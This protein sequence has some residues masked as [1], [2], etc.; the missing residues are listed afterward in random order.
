MSEGRGQRPEEAVEESR[1]IRRFS[2]LFVWQR[3]FYVATEVFVISKSWSP[4][5]RYSLTDQIRRSARSLGAHIAEVWGKRP[6]L[7]TSSANGQDARRRNGRSNTV[8]ASLV[9]GLNAVF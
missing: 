4:D 6:A 3:I 5:E 7:G 9:R 8:S 2:G 1:P